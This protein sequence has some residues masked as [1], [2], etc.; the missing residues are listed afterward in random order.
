MGVEGISPDG[1]AHLAEDFRR[2]LIVEAKS[3][4]TIRIYIWGIN[5]LHDFARKTGTLIDRGTMERWA[6]DASGRM[7]PRSFALAGVA[8]RRLL[9][10]AVKE[11]HI[12]DGSLLHSVP[13]AKY[14]RLK[15]PSTLTPS[16]LM[17]LERYLIALPDSPNPNLHELRDRAL[18]FYVKAT[19]ARVSEIL[20]AT[21]AN[22][23]RQKVR[24][25]GGQEKVLI[26]PPGVANL[27]RQYVAKRNEQVHDDLPWLWVALNPNH[28]V[29]KLQPAGVLK[30]WERL[31]KKVGVRRF[32]TQE[33]RHTAATLLVERGH[34]DTVI[35]ELLGARDARTIQGYKAI[36]SDRLARA[37]AELDVL[38]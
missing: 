13:T 21:K 22:Y 12:R 15:I 26:P 2:R 18:F 10:W 9:T 24:Q 6:E 5:D 33:L 30:I 34:E 8:V 14:E 31:A 3:E 20:Q 37:R 4:A 19:A 32:T 17:R 36:V 29:T 16:T 23:D 38:L 27:I 35:M 7:K 28:T 11:G 1:L 25:K